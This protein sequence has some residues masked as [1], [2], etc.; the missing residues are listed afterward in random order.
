MSAST[1][2]NH[3]HHEHHEHHGQEHH[4]VTAVAPVTPED[5]SQVINASSGTS[6]ETAADLTAKLTATPP[7]IRTGEY[8]FYFKKPMKGASV[9]EG[10]EP[11][12]RPAVTLSLPIPTWDG[13]A[14]MLTTNEK[15]VQYVLDMVEEAIKDQAREQLT[16]SIKPVMRQ[17]ELDLSKLSLE[18]IASMPK[19]ER[20]GGGI[21]KEVWEEF[22][23]DYIAVMTPER[24]ADKSAK[25]AQLFLQRF[26]TVKTEKAVITALRD[27]LATWVRKTQNAE[28]FQEVYTYLDNRASLLLERDSAAL[29][30]A[31]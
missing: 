26:N 16:D 24:G 31:I 13:L 10:T 12:K 17:D 29:L 11:E 20:Q 22:S 8:R 27:L 25:A 28:D 30:S 23:K 19:S 15:V 6:A 9:A 7:L 18:Y 5:S 4:P 2:H 3:E 1:T 21:A 14:T